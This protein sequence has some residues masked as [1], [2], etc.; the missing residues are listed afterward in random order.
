M[1]SKCPTRAHPLLTHISDGSLW[2][3][4]NQPCPLFC[5]QSSG[6]VDVESSYLLVA[7]PGLSPLLELQELRASEELRVSE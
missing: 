6:T 1:I 4:S 7:A 5:K 3:C 2:E